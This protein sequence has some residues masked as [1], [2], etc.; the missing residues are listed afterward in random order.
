MPRRVSTPCLPGASSGFN[1]APVP[2]LRIHVRGP[3]RLLR[4]LGLLTFW[5]SLCPEQSSWLPRSA[6]GTSR[7]RCRSLCPL[8]PPVPS[9]TRVTTLTVGHRPPRVLFTPR[10]LLVSLTCLC[11][12]AAKPVPWTPGLWGL[13]LWVSA[14]R[15]PPWLP[16]MLATFPSLSLSLPEGHCPLFTYFTS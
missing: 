9:Y 16:P 3:L 10:L 6:L 2:R 14:P 12:P 8:A 13:F 5:T 7:P 15:P 1:V 11:A 4:P